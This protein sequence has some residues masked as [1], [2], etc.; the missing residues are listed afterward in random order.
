M[1]SFYGYRL[2]FKENVIFVGIGLM[3]ILSFHRISLNG[4]NILIILRYVFIIMRWHTE[5]KS[6]YIRAYLKT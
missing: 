2:Y 6:C 1:N 3:R 5:I 4:S